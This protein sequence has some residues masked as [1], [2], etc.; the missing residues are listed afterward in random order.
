MQQHRSNIKQ[1]PSFM[2]QHRLNNRRINQIY[3]VTAP[4]GR[5]EVFLIGY[6]FVR[7]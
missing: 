5:E 3:A 1:Q 7:K 6:I 4:L 2:Q